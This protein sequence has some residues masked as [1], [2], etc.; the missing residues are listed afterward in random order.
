[1]PLPQN[2]LVPAYYSQNSICPSPSD[3]AYITM[4][5][6]LTEIPTKI[7]VTYLEEK[8]DSIQNVYRKI[9]NTQ[10]PTSHIQIV[11]RVKLRKMTRSNPKKATA[12]NSFMKFKSDIAPQLVRNNVN[13]SEIAKIA[14]RIWEFVDETIKKKYGAETRNRLWTRKPSEL[15]TSILNTEAGL[16]N[17]QY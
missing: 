10:T 11:D 15:R 2:M 4:H 16:T 12:Q 9:L 14:G 3:N 7:K 1:M 5:T 17:E 8:T 6:S 13:Q